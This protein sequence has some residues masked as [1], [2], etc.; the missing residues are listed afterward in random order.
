MKKLAQ[1]IVILAAGTGL[2]LAGLYAPDSVREFLGL[3]SEEASSQSS[4]GAPAE[5]SVGETEIDAAGE[6]AADQYAPMLVDL[7]VLQATFIPPEDSQWGVLVRK[8]V[9]EPRA[10]A[11]VDDLSALNVRSE[12]FR[13]ED[14]NDMTWY[15]VVAGPYAESTEAEDLRIRLTSAL[16]VDFR[17][18]IVVFPAEPPG[19]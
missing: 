8:Y 18:S 9:S 15:I 12:T 14:A 13:V 4:L 11:L 17:P 16:G 6:E 10:A 5:S 1:L 19:D 7:D 2:F 3:E